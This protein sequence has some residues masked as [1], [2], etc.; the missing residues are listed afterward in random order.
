ME[1]GLE[2]DYLRQH[3]RPPRSKFKRSPDSDNDILKDV[4]IFSRTL[5][6]IS[7]SGFLTH[8][9]IS[10]S[11]CRALVVNCFTATQI[12]VR[13][14]RGDGQS[15]SHLFDF[16][17]QRTKMCL[18]LSGMAWQCSRVIPIPASRDKQ[19]NK[20]EIVLLL[21]RLDLGVGRGGFGFPICAGGSDELLRLVRVL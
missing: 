12:I 20:R 19:R 9:S 7:T 14:T 10:A 21:H 15:V 2:V 18:Q 13:S 11:V 16:L 6:G 17:V 1:R 4:E 3:K 5:F 8:S